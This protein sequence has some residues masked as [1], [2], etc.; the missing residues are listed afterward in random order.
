MKKLIFIVALA[1]AACGQ[2]AGEKAEAEYRIAREAGVTGDQ[3]CE[4]ERRIEH[5]Y[6]RDEDAEKYQKWRMTAASTCNRADI[7]RLM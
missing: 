4:F 2:G 5:A 6:L 7:D 3:A 1:L